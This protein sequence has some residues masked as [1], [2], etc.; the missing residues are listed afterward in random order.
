[1]RYESAWFMQCLLLKMKSNK[2]FRHIES[3]G[4]LPMPSAST[5]RKGISS[6]S[7]QFGFNPLASEH[8]KK[9][10]AGLPPAARWGSL[11]WD[12]IKIKKDL[13]WDSSKL[14]WH[15]TVNYGADLKTK[16]ANGIAD[17][18]LVFMFRPYKHSWIQPFACFA[19]KG[20]ASVDILHELVIKAICALFTHNAIVKN[21]VS[22][23]CQTNK[24]V[25]ALFKVKGTQTKSGAPCKH[26]FL[27]P[28]DE[29]IKIY[30]FIDV[31]HLLKC[32]RNQVFT[33]ER[34]QVCKLKQT[35]YKIFT[36]LISFF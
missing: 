21:C 32:V 2:A 30:I 17:H 18:V 25:M 6:S 11:I 31:P 14:E 36:Y 5:I 4:L 12:E 34:V 1:M 9:A 3:E 8:I 26:F 15:G 16:V 23:S 13:T 7:C 28:L 19:T 24:S 22:D 10:L 20:A 27:H 35:N 29:A 33:H